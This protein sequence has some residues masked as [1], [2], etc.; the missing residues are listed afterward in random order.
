MTRVA[1]MQ[2]ALDAALKTIS[3][4]LSPPPA[5]T[6]PRVEQ[7]GAT[8]RVLLLTSTLG[9]GHL[10]AAQA[11]E[12][13]LLERRPAAKVE[14]LDFWSLM[15]EGVAQA[16]RQTYLRLVQERPELYNRIFQLDERTWP[17]AW[18]CSR[19]PAVL[20]RHGRN[21]TAAAMRW[22]GF[23][24]A[25]FARHFPSARARTPE[26]VCWCTRWS[27]GAGCASRGGWTRVCGHSGPMWWW[28]RPCILR[29]GNPTARPRVCMTVS[30]SGKRR[31]AADFLRN[32]QES[33]RNREPMRAV[34]TRLAAAERSWG[35]GHELAP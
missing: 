6:L 3:G 18:Y 30:R 11:V 8:P 25:C 33:S 32:A 29:T 23:C 9:S 28:R 17:R 24:S 35:H 13:A 34:A 22:T 19:P 16:V 4:R 7:N 14:T 31:S 27:N 20:A 26:T 10:C 12:A 15:D 5:S 2:R 1:A 21:R